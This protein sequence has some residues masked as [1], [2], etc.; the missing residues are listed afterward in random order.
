MT[1][2]YPFYGAGHD[3]GYGTIAKKSDYSFVFQIFFL[4]R[5]Y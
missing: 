2:G 3:F 1:L 5:K 4:A